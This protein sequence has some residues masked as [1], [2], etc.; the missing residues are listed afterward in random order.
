MRRAAAALTLSLLATAMPRA[1]SAEVPQPTP[2]RL[3]LEELAATSSPGLRPVFRG[4]RLSWLG[5]LR[6][7]AAG[8]SAEEMARDFVRRRAPLVALE[9]VARRAAPRAR[10][11]TGR[12]HGADRPA[13][14]QP[15]SPWPCPR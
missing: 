4:E 10:R 3:E 15:P 9:P 5:G 11:V 8:L 7:P 13:P 12:G 2:A 1:S 14:A 6:E